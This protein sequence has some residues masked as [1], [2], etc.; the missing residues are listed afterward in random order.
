MRSFA[1]LI[2]AA[3]L[4]LSVHAYTYT[5]R[6]GMSENTGKKGVGFDPSS[7]A[8]VQ[9]A[10]TIQFVFL[11][12]THSV[13]ESTFESPCMPKD[14]GYDS[15]FQTVADN[16]GEND[17]A[18]PSISFIMSNTSSLWFFDQAAGNCKDGAVFSINPSLDDTDAK[19][20]AAASTAAEV[21]P[22]TTPAAPA[23]TSSGAAGSSSSSSSN[24]AHT[25]SAGYV[26]LLAV[27]AAAVSVLVGF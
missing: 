3:L 18:L 5:I 27:G 1:A 20:K 13:R 4:P 7:V 2:L 22:S 23:A 11:S 9:R 24:A 21:A 12:G 8:A 16:L 19:F 15:G 17:P 6:V 10:D 25:T 26:T 14:N